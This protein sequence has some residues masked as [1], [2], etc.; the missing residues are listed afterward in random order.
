[1]QEH[2]LEM[3]DYEQNLLDESTTVIEDAWETHYLS[4]FLN[5]F[6]T[7][8]GIPL[9]TAVNKIEEQGKAKLGGGWVPAVPILRTQLEA[10]KICITKPNV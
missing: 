8:K 4:M 1:M 7:R 9:R 2:G 10:A 6:Q 3:G 5:S